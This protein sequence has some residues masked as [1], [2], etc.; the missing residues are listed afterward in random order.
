[1]LPVFSGSSTHANL[2]A[3]GGAIL[4]MAHHVGPV[5]DLDDKDIDEVLEKYIDSTEEDKWWDFGT[6]NSKPKMH[7]ID[8]TGFA[9]LSC[10]LMPLLL[11]QPSARVKPRQLY[12]GLLRMFSKEAEK[13]QA[14]RRNLLKGKNAQCLA[15]FVWKR[16]DVVLYHVRRLSN[17]TRFRQA[18][19]SLTPQQSGKLL[20]YR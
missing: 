1:M 17:D 6:Y 16:V 11:V 19:G 7:A 12:D 8:G 14:L 3:W 10:L 2:L 18:S 4:S 15:T 5:K 9:L 20:Q 13:P